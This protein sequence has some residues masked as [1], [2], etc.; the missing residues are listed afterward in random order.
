MSEAFIKNAPVNDFV[1]P[2]TNCV[3][4]PVRRYAVARSQASPDQPQIPSFR[5]I[6]LEVDVLACLLLDAFLSLTTDA[7]LSG[8]PSSCQDCFVSS[9]PSRPV[10]SEI[11]WMAASFSSAQGSALVPGCDD[12]VSPAYFK[13]AT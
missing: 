5:T 4:A 2:S 1:G 11:P 7:K 6:L 10:P 8:P 9:K 13:G 12:A 3:R